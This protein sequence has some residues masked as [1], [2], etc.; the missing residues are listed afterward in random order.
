MNYMKSGILISEGIRKRKSRGEAPRSSKKAGIIDNKGD[1]SIVLL[2]IITE[3]IRKSISQEKL[4]STAKNILLPFIL[5]VTRKIPVIV[6][7]ARINSI[8]KTKAK[9]IMA[10]IGHMLMI[11][12][13]IP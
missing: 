6:A 13:K 2:K 4:F 1:I 9:K 10:R 11:K 5:A 8:L 3:A 7:R 12:L